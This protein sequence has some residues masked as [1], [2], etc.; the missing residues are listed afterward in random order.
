MTLAIGKKAPDF[1]LPR[2]GGGTLN[3]SGLRGRKVVLTFY[4]GH[5]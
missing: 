5:W 2:D 3:L 1:D 4:R